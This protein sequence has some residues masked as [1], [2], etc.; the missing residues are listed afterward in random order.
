MTKEHVTQASRRP[1]AERNGFTRRYVARAFSNISLNAF[2]RWDSSGRF[3]SYLDAFVIVRV[4][5][6]EEEI[7]PVWSGSIRS[8]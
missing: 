6:M 3:V 4:T 8:N 7:E 2:L 5:T 1:S